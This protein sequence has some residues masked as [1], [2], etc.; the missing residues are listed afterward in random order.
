M[1]PLTLSNEPALRR[2]S[3]EIIQHL[4][5]LKADDKLAPIPVIFLSALSETD[6]KVKALRCGPTTVE[7]RCEKLLGE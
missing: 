2:R 5:R 7:P 1:R 6:D 3:Q 4:L